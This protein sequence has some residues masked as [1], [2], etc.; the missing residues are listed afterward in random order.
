MSLADA[1]AEMQEE[2]ATNEVLAQAD[3]ASQLVHTVHQLSMIRNR[4]QPEMDRAVLA[5]RRALLDITI[6]IAKSELK[7]VARE[8]TNALA[9]WEAM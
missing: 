7:R 6:R 2:W 3:R 4:P 1:Q 8:L 5:Q 9:K